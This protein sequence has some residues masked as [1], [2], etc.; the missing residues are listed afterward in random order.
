VHTPHMAVYTNEAVHIM[1]YGAVQGILTMS[2]NISSPHSSAKN[3]NPKHM[4]P[5]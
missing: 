3:T 1:L 2:E 5:Q 4:I